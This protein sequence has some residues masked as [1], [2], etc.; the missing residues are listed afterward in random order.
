MHY[1]PC[2]YVSCDHVSCAHVLSSN[3]PTSGK[4]VNRCKCHGLHSGSEPSLQCYRPIM[5]IVVIEMQ[6]RRS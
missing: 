4:T 6:L 1:L 5:E 2:D 3:S